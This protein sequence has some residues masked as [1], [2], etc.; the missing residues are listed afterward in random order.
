M[1]SVSDSRHPCVG[2]LSGVHLFTVEFIGEDQEEKKKKTGFW[3]FHALSAE[4]AHWHSIAGCAHIN[5]SHFSLF[6]HSFLSLTPVSLSTHSM[7]FLRHHRCSHIN[8][9]YLPFFSCC[10]STL[11]FSTLVVTHWFY[12][13]SFI[14]S[15][16]FVSWVCIPPTLRLCC[17]YPVHCWVPWPPTCQVTISLVRAPV[18]RACVPSAP[19]RD[20]WAKEKKTRWCLMSC[21]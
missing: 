1:P 2:S 7:H 4:S 3:T 12:F 18:P 11:I 16:T 21:R 17:G 8:F 9:I 10:F 19:A 15:N 13:T 20:C 14:H 6:I 5:S